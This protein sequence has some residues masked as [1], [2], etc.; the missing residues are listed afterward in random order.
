MGCEGHFD[1]GERAM[2][3]FAGRLEESLLPYPGVEEGMAALLKRKLLEESALASAEL[4]ADDGLGVLE[5]SSLLDVYA[6]LV[7]M[8]PSGPGTSAH[9]AGSRGRH[10]APA[11]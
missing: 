11:Q 6:D 7:P 10:A 4:T 8:P 3:A 2:Q 5:L 1:V 9:P